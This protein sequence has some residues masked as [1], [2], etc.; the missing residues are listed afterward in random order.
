MK[1]K[2]I[3]I[4]LNELNLKVVKSPKTDE[5]FLMK[6]AW[7]IG[8]TAGI[9]HQVIITSWFKI[10]FAITAAWLLMHWT[11]ISIGIFHNNELLFR[12]K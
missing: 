4:N 10:L 8:T 3:K 12:I 6:S 1:Q 9:V 2:D 5:S 7:F 11:G